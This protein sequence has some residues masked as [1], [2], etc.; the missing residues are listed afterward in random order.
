LAFVFGALG[1]QLIIL[2]IRLNTTHYFHATLLRLQ[3][4]LA[5]ES[6][7]LAFNVLIWNRITYLLD[8]SKIR[9]KSQSTAKRQSTFVQLRVRDALKAM[10][11]LFLIF[12]H[13]CFVLFYTIQSEEPHWLALI[14]FV[15]VAFY[16]HLTIL[17][18]AVTLV[19]YIADAI[20][21]HVSQ[22]FVQT[23]VRL[24]VHHKVNTCT[25]F[26]LAVAMVGVGLYTTSM[27]PTV[28]RVD[29]PIVA[30]PPWAQ[31]RTIALL[32]DLHIGPTV[33]RRRMHTVVESVMALKP[34]GQQLHTVVHI[35]YYRHNRHCWRFVR[36][37]Y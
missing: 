10:I 5:I 20:A 6:L 36:R 14:S 12:A 28:Y 25:T 15:C 29:V 34:G 4:L 26:T 21:S 37:P 2:I 33:G 7:M 16:I 32:T 22:S 30:L 8:D 17:F 13:A 27:P 35:H 19:E 24:L 1:I 23:L 9:S 31:G 11:I 3:M 18:S